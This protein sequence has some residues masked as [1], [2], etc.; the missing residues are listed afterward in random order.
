MLFDADIKAT[1]AVDQSIA[2]SSGNRIGLKHKREQ[3]KAKKIILRE[4]CVM[5]TYAN[6]SRKKFIDLYSE[7]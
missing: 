7:L 6:T 2:F 4:T 3:Q 5:L 1:N